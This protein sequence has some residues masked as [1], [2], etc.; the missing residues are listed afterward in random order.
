MRI[1]RTK[2]LR[3]RGLML[4]AE[5]CRLEKEEE[6]PRFPLIEIIESIRKSESDADRYRLR[7]IG[8]SLGESIGEPGGERRGER[9][10]SGHKS[11]RERRGE[12]VEI[13]EYGY[14]Y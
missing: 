7:T 6:E 12:R 5:R 2:D 13:E 14:N 8:E 10:E 4:F 11:V 9:I 1:I 3:I